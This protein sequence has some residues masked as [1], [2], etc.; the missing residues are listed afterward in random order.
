M[1]SGVERVPESRNTTAIPWLYREFIQEESSGQLAKP[2]QLP[3]TERTTIDAAA[4][5]LNVR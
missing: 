3:R 5:I 1:S 2:Y 4:E